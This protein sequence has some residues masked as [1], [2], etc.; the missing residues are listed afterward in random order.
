MELRGG[1]L[2]HPH[3]ARRCTALGEDRFE[4]LSS[5]ENGD[6]GVFSQFPQKAGGKKSSENLS[7]GYPFRLVLS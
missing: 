2:I 7:W 5:L 4:T 3:R 1:R 6:D